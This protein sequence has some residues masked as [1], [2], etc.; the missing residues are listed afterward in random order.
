MITIHVTDNSLSVTGH[1]E[2]PA[3][4]P[5]GNNI[6]C[7]AVSS[8]TLTLVEGLRE[9]AGLNIEAVTDPGNVQIRWDRMNDIGQALIDT[10]LLG[11]LGI[12]GSYGNITIV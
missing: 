1:A 12:Q 2:R 4:V 11:I 9:V 10:W 3:G 6:I 8:V 5:P 7:A